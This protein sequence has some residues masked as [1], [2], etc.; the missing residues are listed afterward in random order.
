M[1]LFQSPYIIL[2]II[3]GSRKHDS[4]S[5][6]YKITKELCPFMQKSVWYVVEYYGYKNLV[7]PKVFF[8]FIDMRVKGVYFT[9]QNKSLRSIWTISYCHWFLHNFHYFKIYTRIT[10]FVI[11]FDVVAL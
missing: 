8:K 4:T 3:I 1:R 5:V 10:A 11:I 6:Y 2:K 7:R 9:E